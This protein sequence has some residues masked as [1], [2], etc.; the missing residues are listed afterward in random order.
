MFTNQG[1]RRA[2]LLGL[3]T[4]AFA[5]LAAG[6]YAAGSEPGT[7]PPISNWITEPVT[8]VAEAVQKNLWYLLALT[9]PF[10]FGPII[11]LLYIIWRF[12]AKRNP[13]PATFH[14]NVPLEIAWT[15]IPALV[16]VAMAI[17]TLPLIKKIERPPASDLVVNVK[18]HQFFWEY[19]YPRYGVT[20]VDDGTGKSPLVVPV[21][22]VV[23]MNGEASQV[24]HA[25]WV[26]AFGVKFDVIPG[27]ITNGWFKVSREGVFKGQCAELCGSQH[28]YMLIYV[29]VVSDAEFR[30][31]ILSKNPDAKFE[32]PEG[33]PAAEETPT[34]LADAVP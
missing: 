26:P 8:P 1:R 17:P 18:G 31:F 10:L 25:W 3:A 24:N 20:V 22:K 33:E 21:N 9:A 7:H 16:L 15:A 23:T 27:R 6:L 5:G 13:V 28:A 12:D 2:L 30:Q 4:V 19:N 32:A 34:R 29:K 14:E 11:V